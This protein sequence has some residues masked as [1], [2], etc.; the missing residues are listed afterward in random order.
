MTERGIV[1]ADVGTIWHRRIAEAL[2]EVAPTIAFLPRIDVLM[3]MDPITP[4][5]T[6]AARIVKCGLPRGWASSLAVPAQA[7]MALSRSEVQRLLLRQ[8]SRLSS[9]M[10]A[11]SSLSNSTAW[12]SALREMRS[13]SAGASMTRTR[14]V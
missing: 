12:S 8:R 9:R 13:S 2:G 11:V 7:L 10:A 4:P 14:A 1:F 3:W 6:G 5:D